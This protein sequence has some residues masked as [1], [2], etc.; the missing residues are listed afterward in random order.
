M[1]TTYATTA[2]LAD[3]LGV[4]EADL[5]SDASR[6]LDRASEVV[7]YLTLNR[8]D[9][10]DIDNLQAAQKATCAQVEFWI[11]NGEGAEFQGNVKS[12]SIGKTSVT[13]ASGSDGGG[14]DTKFAPRTIRTLKLAGLMNRTGY[15]GVM[16]SPA[17]RFF[18]YEKG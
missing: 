14:S 9:T 13:F 18:R 2:E 1:S 3:Y 10:D 11:E 15:M 4:D 7:D 16:D 17:R 5:P 6:L 12:Y 8:V